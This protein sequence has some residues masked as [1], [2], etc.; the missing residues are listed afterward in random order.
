MTAPQGLP[1]PQGGYRG[2]VWAAP[3]AARGC[4]FLPR[5]D[6]DSVT[7]AVDLYRRWC[8]LPSLGSMNHADDV[9]PCPTYCL[10]LQVYPVYRRPGYWA[11]E[12]LRLHEGTGEPPHVTTLSTT[13][14]DSEDVLERVVEGL[15]L[16]H[17][18]LYPAPAQEPLL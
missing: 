15:T 12:T 2:S 1:S 6:H 3:K 5:P 8:D 17:K 10:S 18:V 7:L 13:I 16:I 14:A 9:P 11:V 4:L